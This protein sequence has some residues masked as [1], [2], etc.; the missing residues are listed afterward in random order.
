MRVHAHVTPQDSDLVPGA[1]L[2]NLDTDERGVTATVECRDDRVVADLVRAWS[3]R[4]PLTAAE[5]TAD[6]LE[7]AFREAVMGSVSAGEDVVTEST[8]K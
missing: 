1:S 6:S 2:L 3:A 5:S 7:E 4:W 8:S